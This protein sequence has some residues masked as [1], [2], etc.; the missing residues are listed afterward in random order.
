MRIIRKGLGIFLV[1][2][3]IIIGIFILQFRTDS[4]IMKKLGNLQITLEQSVSE[5]NITSLLNKLQVTYNGLILFCDDENP[6]KIRLKD[7]SEKYV[8]FINFEQLN[9]LS[10]NFIFEDDIV[11]TAKLSDNSED[12]ELQIF[13]SYPSTVSSFQIPYKY[14]RNMNVK[15]SE[16]NRIVLNNNQKTWDFT[17][18]NV[19]NNLLTFQSATAIAK[20]KIHDEKQKSVEGSI[21]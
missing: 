7:E 11:L 12:A 21:F 8:K 19:Q 5:D 17:A 14:S 13:S 4:F 10:C 15:E 18:T 3:V 9:D 20:Y 2:I 16:S 6:A 1:D